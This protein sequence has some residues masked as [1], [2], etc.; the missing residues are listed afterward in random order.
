MYVECM[1]FLVFGVSRMTWF[2]L[3]KYLLA[4]VSGFPQSMLAVCLKGFTQMFLF[5]MG[6]FK[7]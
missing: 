5:F 4:V 3:S 1:H 2:S 6:V 7:T